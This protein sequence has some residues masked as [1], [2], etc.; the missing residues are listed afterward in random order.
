M[1]KPAR[2]PVPLLETHKD[3]DSVWWPPRVDDPCKV[4]AVRGPRGAL[5]STYLCKIIDKVVFRGQMFLRVKYE[6]YKNGAC[7]GCENPDCDAH[8]WLPLPGRTITF[9]PKTK[10]AAKWKREARMLCD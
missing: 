4:K 10:T 3:P 1:R 9:L 8:E 2:K 6:K 7:D 5:T